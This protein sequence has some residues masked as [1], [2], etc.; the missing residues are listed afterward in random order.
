M[1]KRA[2]RSEDHP[3]GAVTR[4]LSNSFDPQPRC[5]GIE[6][7]QD[8][9]RAD[10]T[11]NYRI[12][13]CDPKMDERRQGLLIDPRQ[14]EVIVRGV[15]LPDLEGADAAMVTGSLAGGATAGAG[16]GTQFQGLEPSAFGAGGSAGLTA[17]LAQA[18]DQALADHESQCTG[19]VVIG[20]APITQRAFGVLLGSHLHIRQLAMALFRG[21][22][23][24]AVPVTVFTW[25]PRAA[26]GRH[27]PRCG[28]VCIRGKWGKRVG[29]S[30]DH[31]FGAVIR[32]LSNSG[33]PNRCPGIECSQDTSRA[34]RTS[35]YRIWRCDP[36]SFTL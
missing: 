1:G 20:D 4:R 28:T 5:P 19:Q 9:S 2:G 6:C 8:A 12:W 3:L 22:R 31:P 18:T 21:R 33:D 25:Q 36:K 27:C 13:R 26:G 24:T 23:R 34:D 29:R 14:Q 7:S 32:R 11:S 16:W 15:L 30:E 35:N 10:R 17:V